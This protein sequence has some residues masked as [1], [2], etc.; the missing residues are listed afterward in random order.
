MKW[1]QK[2]AYWSGDFFEIKPSIFGF[3]EQRS[4]NIPSNWQNR[5][6]CSKNRDL[7]VVYWEQPTRS[8]WNN[9]IFSLRLV[10]TYH[11]ILKNKSFNI[12][13]DSRQLLKNISLPM[14]K[15]TTGLRSRWI[16]PENHFQSAALSV[17][18]KEKLIELKTNSSLQAAFEKKPH[19]SSLSGL[20]WN[21]TTSRIV[22]K[23]D[24]CY[25]YFILYDVWWLNE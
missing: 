23:P 5:I 11:K 3:L 15:K 16:S 21:Q 25:Y 12:W 20:T 2:L 18:E 4:D 17:W 7:K 22:L 10:I 1:L 14:E 19:P 24:R 8:F 9:M 13:M 6:F